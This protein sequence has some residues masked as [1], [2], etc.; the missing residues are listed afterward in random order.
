M[1]QMKTLRNMMVFAV[2]VAFCGGSLAFAHKN[3]KHKTNGKKPWAPRKD[4]TGTYGTPSKAKT[5]SVTLASLFASP[6]TYEGKLVQVKGKIKAAC[7]FKGCW[8]M[9]TD[10]KHKMRI[11][12]KGYG[13]F[14]PTNSAGYEAVVFGKAKARTI[15]V[16]MLRHYAMDAGK[17]ELAKKITK[18]KHTVAF[19][20]DWVKLYKSKAV[21][22]GKAAPKGKK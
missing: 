12:F 2:C 19:T 16:K 20:A 13:F 3:H 4:C 8:M 11:R 14:V 1:K 18:P 10:G 9:L 22:K 17:P 15:S 7:K 6:K 5:T 21:P